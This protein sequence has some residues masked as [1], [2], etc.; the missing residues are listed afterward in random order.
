[1]NNVFDFTS[2]IIKKYYSPKYYKP[3]AKTLTEWRIYHNNF[4]QEHPYVNK[5]ID[6]IEALESITVYIPNKLEKL[7]CYI[8]NKYFKKYHYLKSDLKPHEYYDLDTRMLHGL[9][10]ELVNFVEIECA[11]MS[12]VFDKPAKKKYKLPFYASTRYGFLFPEVKSAQ[13]GLDYIEFQYLSSNDESYNKILELYNWWKN[14]RPIR[15]DPYDS[16][17]IEQFYKAMELKYKT[18]IRILEDDV[19]SEEERKF[20]RNLYK[21]IREQEALQYEEDTNMLIDLI[22]IR[23]YLWT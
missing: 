14:I 4:E 6:I 13:A 20:L 19:L 11:H 5:V 17:D 12:I 7:R 2:D 9:F 3:S 1:M 23:G 18:K 22:K 8:K 10:N 16:D 15:K 21:K